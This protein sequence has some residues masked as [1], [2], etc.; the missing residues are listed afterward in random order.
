MSVVG[1][2]LAN[3]QSS[4]SSL[5][6]PF[7]VTD[8]TLFVNGQNLGTVESL[9]GVNWSAGVTV[10]NAYLRIE[11]TEGS[12]ITSIRF[13]NDTGQDFLVFD[14]FAVFASQS[15]AVPEP[16][17]LLIFGLGGLGLRFARRSISSS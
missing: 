2:G 13:R 15:Q 1:I 6:N 12:L 11:G 7:P 8:H 17:S 5:T 9:A 16:G 4:L 10:R 3:F 14:R